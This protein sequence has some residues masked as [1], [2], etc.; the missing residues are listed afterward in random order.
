M[1]IIGV[2]D[3][4]DTPKTQKGGRSV[5][6]QSRPIDDRNRHLGKHLEVEDMWES[7]ISQRFAESLEHTGALGLAN[8]DASSWY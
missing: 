7:D 2:Y 5:T 1:E 4:R 3:V 8:H 6:L